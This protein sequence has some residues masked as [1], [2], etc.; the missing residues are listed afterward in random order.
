MKVGVLALQGDI[1]EHKGALASAMNE[2]EV[3]GSITEIRKPGQLESIDA[4]LFPGGESTAISKQ[5]KLSGLCLRRTIVSITSWK[6]CRKTSIVSQS[7]VC[8]FS[9]STRR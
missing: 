4:L 6:C 1:S 8:L 3:S 2:L 5:M 9:D 7:V